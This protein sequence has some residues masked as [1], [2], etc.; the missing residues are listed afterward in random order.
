MRR[1]RVLRSA[2]AVAA[3]L[4]VGVIIGPA[5]AASGQGGEVVPVLREVRIA[6]HETFDR[7]VFE[8][9]GEVVPG[10][11]ID[12]PLR[13]RARRGHGRPQRS[14]RGG[15]RRPGADRLHVAGHR[16]LCGVAAPRSA[17]QRTYQL[18][19]DGYRER[20]ARRADRGL[21]IRL[22]V[23][24][25]VPQPGHP[26]RLE[27]DLSDPCGGGRPSLDGACAASP[28]APSFTG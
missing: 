20:G 1:P 8:F 27:P 26:P 11:T 23:G 6:R 15:R 21:R 13:Q 14:P 17:L 28:G 7:V 10:A 12:G 16:H 25:R 19:A 22:D 5:V 9:T 3:L 24:H 4:V 2:I 18:H